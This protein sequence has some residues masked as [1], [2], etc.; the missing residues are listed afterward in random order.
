MQGA[1]IDELGTQ[2][3]ITLE[4]IERLYGVIADAS[5]TESDARAAHH[6]EISEQIEGH[7]QD[8][9]RELETYRAEML[10][11]RAELRTHLESSPFARW[12][13]LGRRSGST[14]PAGSQDLTASNVSADFDESFYLLKYPDVAAAGIEPLAH[15]L[16]FGWK[17]GRTP[18]PDIDNATFLQRHPEV[19]GRA[20]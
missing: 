6:R 8:V 1:Q 19:K 7:A 2:M 16:R 12:R 5:A 13:K 15:Y 14:A 10:L 11:Y 18:H 4:I 9:R 3:A 20:R 17:E